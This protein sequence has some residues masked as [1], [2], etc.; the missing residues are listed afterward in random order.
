MRGLGLCLQSGPMQ[1][2]RRRKRWLQTECN[3]RRHRRAWSMTA[4]ERK[5]RHSR[6]AVCVAAD[7]L[8]RPKTCPRSASRN[9]R[10]APIPAL[11]TRELERL[12][13]QQWG[14]MERL[15]SARIRPGS[16]DRQSGNVRSGRAHRAIDSHMSTDP[17]SGKPSHAW[18]IHW[19]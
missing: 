1:P 10:S 18:K 3:R 2:N 16:A 14:G 6:M 5:T 9:D 8:L 4:Y 11:G 13:R 12:G 7:W 19:E 17:R 15:L